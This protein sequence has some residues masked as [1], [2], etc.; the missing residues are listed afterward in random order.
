MSHADAHRVAAEWDRAKAIG[1]SLDD[2]QVEAWDAMREIDPKS[3]GD[4]RCRMVLEGCK[5]DPQV[6]DVATLATFP[7]ILPAAA[8][9]SLA[10][11]AERLTAEALE[12][13]RA[14]L[15]QPEC[16]KLL[17]LPRAV[18]RVLS[19]RVQPTAAAARVIRYDFHRVGVYTING[20]AAGLFGRMAPRP[21]ID[22][23]AIEVAVLIA[24][25]KSG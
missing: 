6:G 23:S 22:F 10:I 18:R 12:A 19:T 9:R 20:R 4:V 3:F 15:E 8:A 11:L 25:G 13:E 1:P 16:L 14:V 2:V 5:W 17:G 7:L 24:A 21:L